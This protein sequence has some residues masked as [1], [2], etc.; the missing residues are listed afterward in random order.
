MGHA[1]DKGGWKLDE[2]PEVPPHRARKDRRRWCRGKIG[3]EHTPEIKWSKYH[4]YWTARGRPDLAACHWFVTYT[5]Q[6]LGAARHPV[7]DG[8]YWSCHHERTC[9]SCGKILNPSLT[10]SCPDYPERSRNRN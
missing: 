7:P 9:T 8:R 3:I 1:Y 5:M 4:L 6:G 2:A 10:T